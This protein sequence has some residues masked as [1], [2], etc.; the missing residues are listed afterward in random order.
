MIYGHTS[1]RERFTCDGFGDGELSEPNTV[2]MMNRQIC[3]FAY[4]TVFAQTAGQEDMIREHADLSPILKTETFAV[5]K[6]E[7]VY[8][9]SVFGKRKRKPKWV[10]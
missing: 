7:S 8:H 1:M 10:G 3:R 9:R 4:K 5:E 6:E 2:Q